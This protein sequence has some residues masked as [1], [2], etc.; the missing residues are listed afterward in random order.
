MHKINGLYIG[1]LFIEKCLSWN[2][3]IRSDCVFDW[4]G[5]TLHTYIHNHS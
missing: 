3:R 2:H 4:R 1:P 5:W